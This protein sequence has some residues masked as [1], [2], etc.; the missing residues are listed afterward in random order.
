[1]AAWYR[2]KRRKSLTQ[3][4]QERVDEAD[5]HIDAMRI[6][7]DGVPNTSDNKEVVRTLEYALGLIVQHG[8]NLR[9]CYPRPDDA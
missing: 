1:M 2:L 4:W 3:L 5:Y 8:R 6:I 7:I 9:D